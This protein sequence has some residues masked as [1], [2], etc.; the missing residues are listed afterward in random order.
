MPPPPTLAKPITRLEGAAPAVAAEDAV[1]GI[2]PILLD[3]S[4]TLGVRGPRLYGGVLLPAALPGI[5]T[6][7]KLGWSFAWR[8][9]MAA[10][11]VV[12]GAAGLGGVLELGREIGAMPEDPSAAG[13]LQPRDGTQGG[14]LAGAVGAEQRHQFAALHLQ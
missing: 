9:L 13:G 1:A 2:P 14:A 3:V 7:L 5:L 12:T 4:G 6:G 11:I 10:E 8:A